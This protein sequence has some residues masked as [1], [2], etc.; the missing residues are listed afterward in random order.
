MGSSEAVVP[1]SAP[2]WKRRALTWIVL[3]VALRMSI[4]GMDTFVPLH[5]PSGRNIRSQSSVWMMCD[6]AKPA[7]IIREVDAEAELEAQAEGTSRAALEPEEKTIEVMQKFSNQY[8]RRSGTYFCSDR[9]VA[10]VVITGLAHH[11]ETLGAPL[12]PC[13][14][15][16]D[17]ESEVK[18]GYWNCPCV[19]MRERHECHCMLFL[20]SDSPF[21]SDSQHMDLEEVLRLKDEHS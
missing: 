17:K 8:A 7:D 13:R 14:H 21:A 11:K 5:R 18:N 12:C 2:R 4:A 1:P 9:S 10:A 20:K 16:E 15:Y 3:A 6:P 19:P